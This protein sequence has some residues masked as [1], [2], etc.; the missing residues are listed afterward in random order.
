MCLRLEKSFPIN[1][2]I[3]MKGCIMIKIRDLI[4]SLSNQIKIIKI[5]ISKQRIKDDIIRIEKLISNL[6]EKTDNIKLK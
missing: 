6:A 2:Y 4:E 5:N 1:C 3:I